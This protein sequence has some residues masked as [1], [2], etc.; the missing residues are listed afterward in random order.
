[1]WML[2]VVT[3][4]HVQVKGQVHPL[5]KILIMAAA[6]VVVMIFLRAVWKYL[7]NK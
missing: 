5:E 6:V 7:R 4:N 2:A 1:M 3:S